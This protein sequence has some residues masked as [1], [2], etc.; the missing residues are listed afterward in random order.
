MSLF[1]ARKITK[2]DIPD[3]LS[4]HEAAGIRAD[5]SK[6]AYN[7]K[8]IAETTPP[9]VDG[10]QR[11]I[12]GF[13]ALL[14]KT[15]DR[16][17]GYVDGIYKKDH[18]LALNLKVSEDCQ[19]EI[20]ETLLETVK[21]D[22]LSQKRQKFVYLTQDH[23]TALSL[24]RHSFFPLRNKDTSSLVGM[25]FSIAALQPGQAPLIKDHFNDLT[26]VEWELVD[27]H[28]HTISDEVH[29]NHI[30]E[31]SLRT[32]RPI[33]Y[34][35]IVGKHISRFLDCDPLHFKNL[36][37]H[38]SHFVIPLTDFSEYHLAK[39]SPDLR[40]CIQPSLLQPFSQQHEIS[41]E[42]FERMMTLE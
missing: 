39:E 37:E 5:L 33:T 16:V 14:A 23:S 30:H 35:N 8:I 34:P 18:A 25:I 13:W 12:R 15:G 40:D 26:G 2:Q 7:L 11:G 6:L 28:G 19:F 38:D 36:P 29:I 4:F 32:V 31:W 21:R 27:G 10:Y 22:V 24:K 20:N 9:S 42:E 41:D 3:I 1:R 17:V